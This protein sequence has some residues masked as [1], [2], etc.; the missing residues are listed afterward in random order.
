M[1]LAV[2]LGL[3]A[4]VVHHTAWL[5][6]VAPALT[7]P[8]LSV[9]LIGFP[10]FIIVVTKLLVSYAIDTVREIPPVPPVTVDTLPAEE[11]LV[12]SSAEPTVRQSEMLLRAAT[13]QEMPTEELLRVG[14]E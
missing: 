4:G 2:L 10:I 13:G 7:K 12:R 6:L 3:F 14:Q 5:L 9:A 11:V 8:I 1:V